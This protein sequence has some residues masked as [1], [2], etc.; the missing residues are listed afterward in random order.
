GFET[1]W[2]PAPARGH[3]RTS[4]RAPCLAGGGL[5]MRVLRPV[6]LILFFFLYSSSPAM[7][8]AVVTDLDRDGAPDILQAIPGRSALTVRPGTAVGPAPSRYRPGAPY[9]I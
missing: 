9:E 1:P 7:P 6:P 2:H 4:H 8:A 5:E 3:S